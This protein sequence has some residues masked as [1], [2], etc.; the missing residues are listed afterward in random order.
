MFSRS[1]ILLAIAGAVSGCTSLAASDKSPFNSIRGEMLSTESGVGAALSESAKSAQAGIEALKT[2]RYESASAHFNQALK[3][4]ARSSRLH[5]L[6][7]LAYHLRGDLGN[8]AMYPLAANGYEVAL[9]FEP[10]NWQASYLYGRML[11]SIREYM[12]AQSYLADAA[13]YQPRNERIKRDLAAASYFAGDLALSSALYRN[14]ANGTDADYSDLAAAGLLSA[15]MND[16]DSARSYV[17]RMDQISGDRSFSDQSSGASPSAQKIHERIQDWSDFYGFAEKNPNSKSLVESSDA[18]I[19]DVSE[20]ENMLAVDV[21]IIR[22]QDDLSG[23]KG[24]NLLDGLQLQFGQDSAGTSGMSW[25]SLN[26]QTSGGTTQ[27]ITRAINI[28]SINYSLNIVNSTAE[29]TRVLAT[30]TLVATFDEESSFFSGVEVD[31]SVVGGSNSDGDV[32]NKTKEI[33][34]SLT[35]TPEKT[36]DGLLKLDVQAE[37]TFLTTPN[38]QS[39]TYTYRIDTSKTSLDANVVMDYGQTLILG[40]LDDKEGV[41]TDNKVPG[42][43]DVPILGGLFSREVKSGYQKS[44][45]ILLTPKKPVFEEEE[46]GKVSVTQSLLELYKQRNEGVLGLEGVVSPTDGLPERWVAREIRDGDLMLQPLDISQI[47]FH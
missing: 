10:D 25:K 20:R 30:P 26:T 31:V 40:G 8:E 27:T 39:I 15:A 23:S 4:N 38:T 13:L 45:L 16:A 19:P 34:V 6:N 1:A 36:E 28:P 47:L 29:R 9:R 33:G 18:E 44:V 5:F 14:L 2:G 43:G 35:I 37:R 46:I 11:F 17:E 32:Y 22:T 3:L 24:V 42:L 41:F 21:V 12:A 7:A